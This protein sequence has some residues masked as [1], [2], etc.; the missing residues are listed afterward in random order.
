VFPLLGKRINVRPSSLSTNE[1]IPHNNL[2]LCDKFD[3]LG[4]I[5]WNFRFVLTLLKLWEVFSNPHSKTR[6]INI[7][8][9]S[10]IRVIPKAAE[11]P[12][13]RNIY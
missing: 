10:I 9:I 7:V 6:V 1:V 4:F 5:Y 11:M 13:S 3:K 8:L 2:G 12:N